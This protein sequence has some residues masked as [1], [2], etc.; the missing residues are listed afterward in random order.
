MTASG[1]VVGLRPYAPGDEPAWD[2]LVERSHNGTF[3]HT[4]AFL[5]HHG[6]RF[7][8]RSVVFVDH[9]GAVV[10]VLPAALDPAEPSRVTSHPGLT[11]GGVVHAG[12]LRGDAMIMALTQAAIHFRD[13]GHLTFRYK[14]VPDIY[15]RVRS[16]DDT[17][18]LFR[19]AASR[20]RCDLS[21]AVD[22]T[23]PDTRRRDRRRNLEVAMAAGL[24]VETGS[25]W[26]APFWEV[27]EDNLRLKFG[28]TPVHSLAEISQLAERFPEQISCHAV[29][30]GNDRCL[31]GLVNFHTH[32]VVHCQ[33]SAANEAGFKAKALDVGFAD[34]IATTRAAGLRWYDFGTC[35]EQEGQVLNSGLYDFKLS[36][37]AGSLAHEFYDLELTS[38]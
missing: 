24:R 27:L 23:S 29:L 21:A 13:L 1:P 25:S 10:G 14:V 26:L 22:V 11:Y 3:L 15:H 12:D 16:A 5:A 28:T 31:A 6:A 38:T 34:S 17:Y 32:T 19:L 33:Y 9:K 2:A 20:Y 18:A 36:F 4:R 30:D 7:T 37:G 8:D 35:N